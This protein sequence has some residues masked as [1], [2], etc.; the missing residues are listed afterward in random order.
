MDEDW[1]VHRFFTAQTHTSHGEYWSIIPFS[2]ATKELF[3]TTK[4]VAVVLS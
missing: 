2:R 1:Q 3:D 4:A